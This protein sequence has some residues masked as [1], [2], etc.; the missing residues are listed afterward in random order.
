LTAIVLLEHMQV[1]QGNSGGGHYY[2]Y[3]RPDGKTWSKYDDERVTVEDV[4][5]ATEGQ[6][7]RLRK[8]L[9]LAGSL[10]APFFL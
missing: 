1:H 6:Y 9:E 2:A 4:K 10:L 8:L 7:G 5:A 3:M